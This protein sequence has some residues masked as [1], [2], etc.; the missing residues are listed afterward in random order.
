MTFSA[1]AASRKPVGGVDLDLARGHVGLVDDAAHAAI[2]IDVAVG[3]DHRL[4]RLLAAMLVVEVHADLRRLRGDQRVDD[5]DALRAF[6]DRHVRQ[7]EVA[8]LVD[9]VRDLEQPAE[10]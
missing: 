7:I 10:C 6:D 5:D 1:T 4:H 8:D 2:V 9:A 3:V